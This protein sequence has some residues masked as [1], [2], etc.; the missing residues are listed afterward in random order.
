VL[1]ELVVE[2]ADTVP[3]EDSRNLAVA[4]TL[5]NHPAISEPQVDYTRSLGSRLCPASS[6][7]KTYDSPGVGSGFADDMG[8]DK[9][10]GKRRSW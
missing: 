3:C 8:V 1:D 4:F 6:S 2:E 9:R 5:G 10:I 7:L